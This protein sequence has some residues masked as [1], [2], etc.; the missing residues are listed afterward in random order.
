MNQVKAQGRDV[1]PNSAI[2]GIRPIR[3]FPLLLCL[4]DNTDGTML[5]FRDLLSAPQPSAPMNEDDSGGEG[6]Q[7]G[8]RT[9]KSRRRQQLSCSAC[10]ARKQKCDRGQP[11]D[12]CVKVSL[13]AIL[14]GSG[15][16]HVLDS[17]D[18]LSS[19]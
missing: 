1:L 14:T 10:H 2:S 18:S 8:P 4:L 12:R 15:L 13:H 6:S 5:G 17:G 7:D 9:K 19:A 11:C 16:N 3:D